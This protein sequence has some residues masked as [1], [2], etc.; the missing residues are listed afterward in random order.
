MHLFKKILK[1]DHTTYYLKMKPAKILNN[2]LFKSLSKCFSA[3]PNRFF[4]KKNVEWQG[5]N[6]NNS[7]KNQ[8]LFLLNE[9]NASEFISKF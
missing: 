5:T 7:Q 8:V 4:L 6:L 2:Q 3:P 1:K 9:L